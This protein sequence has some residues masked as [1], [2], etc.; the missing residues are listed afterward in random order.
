[1]PRIPDKFLECIVYLYPSKADAASASKVGGTG[2]LVGMPLEGLPLHPN[3]IYV[4]TN[5]HVAVN[6]RAVRINTQDGASD[7]IPM[8]LDEWIPHHK[9]DD[10]A[11]FPI[12]L[13]PQR[14]RY[15]YMPFELLLT[16]ER[17]AELN[18]GPGDDVYCMGRFVAHDGIHRNE[19]IVRFGTIAMMPGEPVRQKERAFDQE[20]F[21]VEMRSLS[22]F[23]GSPVMLYVSTE[24]NRFETGDW[25]PNDFV[26][27]RP[28]ITGL[29]GVDWGNLCLRDK[30]KTNTGIMGV[31]PVWKLTELLNQPEAVKMRRAIVDAVAEEDDVAVLD[32]ARPVMPSEF[33]RFEALVRRVVSVPKTEIDEKREAT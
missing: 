17:L 15:T 23:S 19:P 25:E 18:V 20:S 6:A 21:L 4:V 12:G 7:V 9:D 16:S 29:M 32:S 27:N 1:M 28:S 2:F 22:G 11:I 31:V 10:L 14:F 30:D 3:F 26:R 8:S 33:E 24:S 13:P 5:H